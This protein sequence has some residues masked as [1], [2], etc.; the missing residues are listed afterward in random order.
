MVGSL[1]MAGALFSHEAVQTHGL[2]LTAKVSATEEGQARIEAILGAARDEVRTMLREHRPV[3]ERL[4]DA[5]LERD[6]L[7]GDEIL[8]EIQSVAPQSRGPLRIVEVDEG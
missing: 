5:L 7:M 8:D 2:D 1:G 6:E 3:V 4:R